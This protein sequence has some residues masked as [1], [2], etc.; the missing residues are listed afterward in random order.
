MTPA[1]TD[2]HPE[3]ARILA[4]TQEWSADRKAGLQLHLEAE[5]TR[6]RIRQR[7]SHPAELGVL[8]DPA[9]R[10]T[11]AVRRISESVERT[12]T[13][14]G[15]NLLV[16]MP[17]QE[18]KSYL[19]AV[20]T[21]LRALQLDPDCRV[22]LTTYAD[23]LA[24]EHSLA[25]RD[26]IRQHGT[27]VV[28]PLTGAPV[29]DK[30]GLGL[31]QDRSSV[32][33][34]RI[35]GGQGGVVAAGIGSSITGRRA[36]LL[37]I[38][39]PYKNMQEADSAAHRLRVDTWMRSVALT[40]LSPNA[41]VILIQTRWHPEDLAGT[42]LAD[43]AALPL[44]ERSWRHLN[45]PAVSHPGVQDA[46]N[47]PEPGIPM[48]SAR[49]RTA[50]Q[51][52]ATR[53]N[54]GERV[55]FALYQGVPAP[56]EGG[57]FSR[58]WFDTH[59]LEEE[60]D[61]TVMRVVA[62]DPSESGHGDEAGI[63][64]ASLTPDGTVAL[65]HDRSEQMTSEQWAR[66][67]VMLALDTG[68]SEIAV[69]AFTAKQTYVRVIK[70]AITAA[71]KDLRETWDGNDTEVARKLRMLQGIRV[72]PWTEK[73]DS[74][75]RSALLRQAVEVGACRVVSHRLS[76]MEA[77]AALWQHGQHQPDRVAAA[78]IAFDRLTKS[79]GQRTSIGS[80]LQSVNRPQGGNTS[81]AAW[82]SKRIG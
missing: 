77:Q 74:V 46:L 45:I 22:V 58:T 57:L 4:T 81:R 73:G 11:E 16:T 12:L 67:A 66:A 47:R 63:I 69:E 60:P 43:E 51:F 2:V 36:D 65:T 23:A 34:W 48:E 20:L 70:L 50:K 39:D 27:G 76:E 28:D 33:R 72:H 8:L 1:L 9:Y 35:T 37:I 64:A 49:G 7:C 5:A 55:W 61:R 13:E 6:L 10:I 44:S 59:R 52:H 78:L 82:L 79:R 30:L 40:R 29:E 32:G 56:P 53:R 80:P 26:L 25:A 19:C 31:R 68:A 71:L 3:A 17:P 62:V 24:E 38:D 15:R 75:A 21:P 18:G 41:S 42:I 14:P 54:V